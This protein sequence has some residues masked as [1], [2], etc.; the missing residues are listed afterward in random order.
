MFFGGEACF[1]VRCKR[2]MAR[3]EGGGVM[4]GRRREREKRRVGR[5]GKWT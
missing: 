1:V 2:R 5:G 4:M 3:G